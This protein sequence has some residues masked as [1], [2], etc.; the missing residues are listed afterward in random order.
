MTAGFVAIG[1]PVPRIDGRAK[2]TGQARDAAEIVTEGLVHGVV[3]HPCI[4]PTDTAARL[5]LMAWLVGESHVVAPGAAVVLVA[6]TA[7]AGTGP[8][9]L[10]IHRLPA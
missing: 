4:P 8:N 2:V 5:G 1:E 7:A 6:S 9:L 3:P 10:E